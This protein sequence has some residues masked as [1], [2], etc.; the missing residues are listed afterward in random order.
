[1]DNFL[2]DLADE[3]SPSAVDFA[4]TTPPV[5]I[6]VGTPCG[7]ARLLQTLMDAGE[8][9]ETA[10]WIVDGLADA[11]FELTTEGTR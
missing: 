1:M 4:R 3:P 10:Q 9:W 11:G 2:A 6:R 7:R 8:S 5:L